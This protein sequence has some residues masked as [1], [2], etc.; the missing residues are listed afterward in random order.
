MDME[1]FSRLDGRTTIFDYWSVD[2]IRNWYNNGKI[3]IDNL[4]AE[5]KSLRKL[6]IKLLVLCNSSPAIREGKFFDLMYVNPCS[7]DFNPNKQFAFM[8]FA[9]N[10]LLLIAINFDDNDVE[11]KIFIPELAFDYFGIDETSIGPAT[12]LLTN[13]NVDITIKKNKKCS[14]KLNKLDSNLIQFAIINKKS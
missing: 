2:S 10:E 9:E 1:G 13:S 8:R 12:E 14:L 3:S 5:Q 7:V 6:Y 4:T 11:L